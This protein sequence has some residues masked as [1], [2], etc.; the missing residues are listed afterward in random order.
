MPR[1][2]AHPPDFFVDVFRDLQC[3]DELALLGTA[4]AP[5]VHRREGFRADPVFVLRAFR[6]A[7]RG[8]IATYRRAHSQEV[9]R[10]NLSDHLG[11]HP[12][13]L[14]G[15]MEPT[16]RASNAFRR[17]LEPLSTTREDLREEIEKTGQALCE[18]LRG[19]GGMSSMDPPLG[20]QLPFRD[21]PP[22]EEE[23]DGNWPMAGEWHGRYRSFPD[24]DPLVAELEPWGAGYRSSYARVDRAGH[25]S[26]YTRVDPGA[27][28]F[29]SVYVRTLGALSFLYHPYTP[30]DQLD[31]YRLVATRGV[32]TIVRGLCTQIRLRVPWGRLSDRLTRKRWTNYVLGNDPAYFGSFTG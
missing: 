25:R 9:Q 27:T 32:L 28:D 18:M 23:E 30:A 17:Y 13:G 7:F 8:G 19:L 4:L 5:F 11:A 1:A 31:D 22:N 2:A 24:I 3:E 10:R 29:P 15:A 6:T 16:S 21:V 14:A 26:S 12:S 20:H